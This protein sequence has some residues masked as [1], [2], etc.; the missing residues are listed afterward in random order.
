MVKDDY[1]EGENNKN[2]D[3]ITQKKS[4]K[5]KVEDWT[6]D[7]VAVWLK[8]KGFNDEVVKDLKEVNGEILLLLTRQDCKDML[9]DV[10]GIILFNFINQVKGK[11]EEGKKEEV[12]IETFSTTKDKLKSVI[13]ELKELEIDIHEIYY[14]EGIQKSLLGN[15]YKKDVKLP[16]TIEKEN[17]IDI[18]R[19]AF[20]DGL[21]E[22]WKPNYG[23]SK[24]YF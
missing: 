15:F 9:N 4:Y 1:K 18:P 13:A 16:I 11:K 6:K 21:I 12:P 3:R 22:D 20:V 8:D 19:F 17:K 10:N 5:E 7:D 24:K 14:N 23:T 2:E